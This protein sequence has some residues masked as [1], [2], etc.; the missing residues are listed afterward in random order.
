MRHGHSIREHTWRCVRS[1]FLVLAVVFGPGVMAT[2]FAQ[3]CGTWTVI[4]S[5]NPAGAG[6]VVLNS[7]D[8]LAPWNA[9]AVGVSTGPLAGSPNDRDQSLTMHWDGTA[10]SIV[11]SPSPGPNPSTTSVELT[12]VSGL[13]TNEIWAV[14]RKQAQ[15]AGGYLGSRVF[16]LRWDGLTWRDMNAPGPPNRDGSVYTGASGEQFYGVVALAS[17]QV[18]MIG[19][20]WS[21]QPG[22]MITWP[23]V[24]MRWNGSGFDTYELPMV[25]SVGRQWANAVAASASNDVWVVGEGDGASGLSYIWHWNGSGWT[26]VPGPAPGSDHSLNDVVALGPNDVWAGGWWRDA[27]WTTHPLLLHWNGSSWTQV[28]T[29]AGGDVLAAWAPDGVLTFGVGGWARWDGAQWTLATGPAIGSGN[30]ADMDVVSPCTLWGVGRQYAGAD[31]TTLTVKLDATGPPEDSD[32]DGVPD[33]TDNCP[34]LHNPDQADCDGDGAGDACEL[35]DGTAFDCNGNAM[36]DTCETFTDCNANEV[37]DTCEVDCNANGTPDDCD[38]ASGRSADCE[39][40]GI[41]DSCETFDDCNR[42]QI[43]DLCD[44]AGGGSR[45]NN[46]NGHPDECEALGPNDLTV[47]T[48]DD[49]VDFGGAQ[50]QADLPGLDGRVSFREAV[51]AANNTPGPQRIAFNIPRSEYWLDLSLAILRLESGAFFVTDDDTTLDFTTQTAFAGDTNPN[52]GEVGIFGLEANAWGVAAMYITANRC[53]LKGL[54]HVWQRGYGVRIEG[55]DNLVIGSTI[56]GPYYAAVYITGGW[57]GPV[58]SGNVI[59]GVHPGEGNRLSSGDGLRIDGPAANNIVVGN[60]L[61]GTGSGVSIR[62]G[63]S[64]NRIGGPTSAERNVISGAGY[65]GE[66]GCPVGAQVS[67]DGSPG[68]VVEGNYVGLAADGRTSA[69]QAGTVGISVFGSQSTIVRNNAIGGILVVGTNHCNGIR[70]GTAVA[71]NGGSANTLV[72]GNRIGTDITGTVPVVNRSGIV[73]ASAIQGGTPTATRIESNLVSNSET[74]GILVGPDVAGV[75]ISANGVFDNGGLGISL[76]GSGN[77]AQATPQVTAAESDDVSVF[78]QGRI[79]S[80][81]VRTYRIELFASPS[82]DPSGF[83]E[84]KRFLGSTLVVTGASG[85]GDFSVTLPVFVGAGEVLTATATDQTSGNTSEFSACRT[86]TMRACGSPPREVEGLMIGSDHEL[87]SWSPFGPSVHYDL[88]RGM[89]DAF[90]AAPLVC[91]AQGLSGSAFRDSAMPPAAQS[92][93]YDVRATN[94]CGAGPWGG[95]TLGAIHATTCP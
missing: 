81:P 13:R 57:Q 93:C 78:A 62:G 87:V 23:G 33:A 60:T 54:G 91:L 34:A 18:W 27:V 47:T 84:G 3:D 74:V 52:G 31:A 40:N 6:R 72:Q 32:G 50:E 94:S 15:D 28:S 21:E 53:T 58:A 61:T 95:S 7:V 65:F 24:A 59:G 85:H 1:W 25:S 16:A 63:A 83:G 11:P 49:I 48:L 42:N 17:D 35:A 43:N 30:I 41:P 90:G 66:E 20:Y 37:P 22:G 19:R 55:N 12:G 69:G 2:A 76:S 77:G 44:L 26:H 75:T 38:I 4:P 8:V 86:I 14:G 82:C 71:V 88:G 79:D 39:P 67:I 92:F 73:V 56:S 46:T 89:C 70:Y 68:N 36:P 9:W 64:G 5:P 29:P 80:L 10:W 51:A 45:D